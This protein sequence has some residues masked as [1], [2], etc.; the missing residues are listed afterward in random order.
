MSDGPVTISE[1][2]SPRLLRGAKLQFDKQREQW[3]ILGPERVFVPDPVALEI[4][5]RCTGNATVGAIVDDLVATY[6]APREV[7]LKDVSALLQDLAN[8]RI[9]T[10]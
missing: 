9:V 10:A 6:A 5:K 4:I 3:V 1:S 2:S 7:I 8:K